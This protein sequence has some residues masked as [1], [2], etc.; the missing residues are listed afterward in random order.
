MLTI[1]VSDEVE[2]KVNNMKRDESDCLFWKCHN[3][4]IFQEDI[5][6]MNKYNQWHSLNYTKKKLAEL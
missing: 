5:I 4:T 2:F 6:V 3:T 1:S